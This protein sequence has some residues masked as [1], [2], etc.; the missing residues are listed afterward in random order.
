MKP[1]AGDGRHEHVQEHPVLRWAVPSQ[2]TCD[3]VNQIA[4]QANARVAATRSLRSGARA[5]EYALRSE[6]FP[7][8][9]DYTRQLVFQ[10]L[11]IGRSAP[12]ISPLGDQ[13]VLVYLSDEAT[14]IQFAKAARDANFPWLVD[15]VPAYSSVGIHYD[16]DRVRQVDVEKAMRALRLPAGAAAPAGRTHIV[17][18]CYEMQLDLPRVSEHTGLSADEIIKLHSER[19]YTVY[20]I[21]FAP[22]FPYL[23]YLPAALCGVLRLPSPRLRVEPGS[24]GLTG[25]QTGI[26]PQVRPG[27]WNLIGRTPLT[28]VDVDDGYFPL[29]VGDRVMFKRIDEAEFRRLEGERLALLQRV[30]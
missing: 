10:W 25:K 5:S 29:R 28:L 20:A 24:V 21:G 13:A 3:G 17:P 16:A 27:G 12:T 4:H 23:G 18:C 7:T 1:V 11:P 26:Y 22:G 2:A 9:R 15:V 6:D 30:W 8:C 14:A 19:E